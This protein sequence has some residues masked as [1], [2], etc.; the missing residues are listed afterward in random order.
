MYKREIGEIIA[1]IRR[2]FDPEESEILANF[3]SYAAEAAFAFV[4]F[5]SSLEQLDGESKIL[6]IGAGMML[7]SVILANR[8]YKV[9]ALEPIGP[10]FSHFDKMQELV[11]GWAEENRCSPEILR[12]SAEELTAGPK[13]ELVISSN[14]MEHVRNVELVIKASESVLTDRGSVHFVCPNYSFPYEPHFHMVTLFTKRL[15]GRLRRKT[16]ETSSLPDASGIWESL[17][18]IT[19]RSVSKICVELGFKPHF[20]RSAFL[21]Y[22]ERALKD[23]SFQARKGGLVVSLIRFCHQLGILKLIV[24]ITP[25]FIVPV[26]D[27]QIKK[28]IDQ[29]KT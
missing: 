2:Q 7:L 4:L 9:T 12:C 27:C 25:L 5:E 6:E 22:L 1:T 29:Q 18:W 20:R 10:G 28:K 13:Y 14:V 19:L 11:L 16:L 15:T 3:D 8:G 26:I 21:H 17:N 23:K 24:N